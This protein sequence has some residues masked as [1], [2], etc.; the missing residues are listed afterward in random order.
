MK[1]HKK[2][3]KLIG[4]VM[5]CSGIVA[6]AGGPSAPTR[7]YMIDSV[8]PTAGSQSRDMNLPKVLVSLDP[9]E[10]PEYLNR[11]QIVTHL[12]GAAYQLDEFNQWLEPLGENLTRVIGENLSEMLAADGIDI[13]SM[14]RPAETDFNVSV[15][16]LRLDVKPG[17]EMVLIARWSLLDRTKNTMSLTKRSVIREVVDDDSYQGIVKVQN[18]I[19]ESLSRE[20]AEGIRAMVP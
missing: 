12:D 3:I 11:P 16:V 4:V 2:I 8:T 20:I 10:I 18:G 5:I 7:F 15:Q 6:C 1:I 13:L 9:V 19:I 14:S 17:R